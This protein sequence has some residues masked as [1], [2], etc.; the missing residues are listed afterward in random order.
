[1]LPRY[2]IISSGLRIS[3]IF[4]KVSLFVLTYLQIVANE[5]Y[6]FDSPLGI[7]LSDLNS[8]NLRLLSVPEIKYADVKNPDKFFSIRICF[9]D[10]IYSSLKLS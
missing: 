9:N 1:M 2:F 4:K 5:L 7:F 8:N 6:G 10:S 3:F